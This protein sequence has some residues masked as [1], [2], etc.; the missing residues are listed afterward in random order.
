[1]ESNVFIG[2]HC[3]KCKTTIAIYEATGENPTCPGCGGPLQA[4]SDGPETQVLANVT[5]KSCGS[6]FGLISVV[7][8]S[9][10]CPS[11]GNNLISS[12]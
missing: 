5:C 8:G 7:G 1:M 3:P 2:H 11:C 4:A 12:V 9:A 6:S 10:K